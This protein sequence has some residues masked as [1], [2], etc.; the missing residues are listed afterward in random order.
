MTTPRCGRP[1]ARYE[2]ANGPMLEDPVCARPAGHNGR[3][4]SAA[5]LARKYQADTARL[6]AVARPCACGCGDMALW[7]HQFRRGHNHDSAG[8]WGTAPL[9]LCPVSRAAA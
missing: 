7:G 5:A 4:R 3:C 8:R 6:A 1:M 2:A 9:S